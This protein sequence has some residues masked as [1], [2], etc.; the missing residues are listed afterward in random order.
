MRKS[1]PKKLSF[2]TNLAS[3]TT[4]IIAQILVEM[5]EDFKIK[6]IIN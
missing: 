6:P 1:E 2:C 4:K 5:N 3:E